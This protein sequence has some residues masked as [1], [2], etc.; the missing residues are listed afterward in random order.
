M[1]PFEN[2]WL[3]DCPYDWK[4]VFYRRYFVTYLYC[5]PL[6]IT[7][8]CLKKYLSSKCR[9]INLSPVKKS[10]RRLSF[11][12]INIFCEKGIFVTNVYWKKTLRGVYTNFN[13]FIP[14]I[15]KTG[16]IES[17]LLGC[18]SLYSAL[19]RFHYE[20]NI[21]RSFCVKIVSRVT[22]LTNV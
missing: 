12:D 17:F 5:F 21:L 19:V 7:W 1:D 16:L 14:E 22:S 13:S 3:K 11:S 15:W 20:I 2:K 10:D 18:F 4:P 8:R 6:Q 9:N